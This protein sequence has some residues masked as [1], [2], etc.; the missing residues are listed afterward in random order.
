[1]QYSGL[2]QDHRAKSDV[3]VQGKDRELLELVNS[4]LVQVAFAWVSAV[5]MVYRCVAPSFCSFGC[6]PDILPKAAA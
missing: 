5:T 2:H 4:A 6:T 3:K 1:V